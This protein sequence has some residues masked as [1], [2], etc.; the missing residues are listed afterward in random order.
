MKWL[1]SVIATIIVL[2][3]TI[4]P[5]HAKSIKVDLYTLITYYSLKYDIDAKMIG[6]L[7]YIES[8][9]NP[10][11]TSSKNARGLMQVTKIVTKHL[12]KDYTKLYQPAYNI[13]VGCAYLQWLLDYKKNDIPKT[14]KAYYLGPYHSNPSSGNNF[15]NKWLKTY[16]KLSLEDLR[17]IMFTVDTEDLTT[18]ESVFFFIGTP[19]NLMCAKNNLGKTKYVFKY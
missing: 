9:N 14:I 17:R 4:S 5:L 7:I 13:D 16:N 18:I 1:L 10:T 12:D 15:Y 3:C 8:S 6:A 19:T 2:L 11:V